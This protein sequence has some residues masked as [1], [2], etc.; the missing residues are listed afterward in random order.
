MGD[1]ERYRLLRG[2]YTGTAQ[3][4]GAR[5]EHKPSSQT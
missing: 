1:I 4:L 2:P 3:D 5:H